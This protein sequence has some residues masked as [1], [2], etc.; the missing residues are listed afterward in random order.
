[1]KDI[2]VVARELGL[3]PHEV[4]R[5][6]EAKLKVKL[7]ALEAR[8]DAPDGQLVLVTAMNPTPFGEG[9]T[10]TTIG[11]GDG[12]RR[13]GKR[14]VVAIREPS[15]GPVFGVKGGGA[16]GGRARAVPTAD[17]N[18]HFTGDAHAITAA[19]NLITALAEAHVYHHNE[20]GFA[21]TGMRWGR[22]LD[23]T[24]RSLRDIVVGLGGK[25]NGIPR[26]TGFDITAASEI[27]ALL[28]LTTGYADLKARLA[29]IVLGTRADGTAV[30]VGDIGAAGAAAVL[31]RDAVKPNLIQ[32]LEGTPLLAHTGPF[33]NIASGH[34]SVIEDRLALKLGEIVTTEAGFGSDLG[35]EKFCHLVAPRLG[36]GPDVAVLVTTVR[37]LKTHGGQ[38]KIAAGKPLPAALERE[39]ISLVE[40]GAPNLAAHIANVHRVG[41]PVVVCVNRFPH[42]TPA[43]LAYA[44][45]L[46]RRLG[47]DGAAISEGFAK[48]GEGTE[49]LGREVLRVLAEKK[50]RF[51]PLFPEDAPI[52]DKVTRIATQ[53]YGAGSVRFEPK[54][55][56]ALAELERWGLGRLPVC[57]AKTQYS[58]SHDA[59][60][61]GAPRDFV[62]P[63]VNLEVAAGA[64]FVKV[65]SGDILTM[66]GFGAKPQ[67]LALSIDD[68]G[69]VVGL[70]D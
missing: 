52:R 5:V 56:K 4:E 41:V 30:T 67:G 2:D 7:S 29:R 47:A 40:A 16:G 34:N 10:V 51:E 28:A 6:G 22:V 23:V 54:A 37:G 25:A 43:E 50:A 42:D 45:G 9:K 48:G 44:L 53:V 39:D 60:R 55:E 18:L 24:D 26:Q 31:L 35:F 3:Q 20:A 61:L 19:H 59:E 32:T 1:M 46:A 65:F 70:E 64:G 49:A 8:R 66:P 21:P 33:G 27:M 63:V 62:L 14:A 38:L 58:L 68:E 13:L 15:L 11:L 12:L 17:L 69:R 57:M 36:R